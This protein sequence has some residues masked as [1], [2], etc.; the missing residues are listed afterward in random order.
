MYGHMSQS[1]HVKVRRQLAAAVLSSYAEGPR[2][3]TQVF[4]PT[5]L[6]NELLLPRRQPLKHLLK[7]LQIRK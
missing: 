4:R 5:S 2:A 3:R 7:G 6:S 1:E